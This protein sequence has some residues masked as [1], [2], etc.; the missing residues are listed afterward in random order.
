VPRILTPSLQE[1]D[2]RHD[3]EEGSAG[4]IDVVLTEDPNSIRTLG[5]AAAQEILEFEM[6]GTLAPR[7]TS[8]RKTARLGARA[9]PSFGFSLG[10]AARPFS[11][12]LRR[13]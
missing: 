4:T 6:T 5:R 9:G 12:R 7:M 1:K 13:A 8:G 11:C 2:A 3:R 10:L